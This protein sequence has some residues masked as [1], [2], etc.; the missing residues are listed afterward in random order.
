MH[1]QNLNKYT[2]P[3]TDINIKKTGLDLNETKNY[4]RTYAEVVSNTS[5]KFEK[6]QQPDKGNFS[7]TISDSSISDCSLID[8]FSTKK[9]TITKPKT[10]AISKYKIFSIYIIH[11]YILIF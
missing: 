6:Q 1:K 11:L 7:N 2:I 3:V 9:N 10:K 5:K 8:A 4:K